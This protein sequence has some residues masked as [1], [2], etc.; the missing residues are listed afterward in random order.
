MRDV[1]LVGGECVADEVGTDIA[2][3]GA[4]SSGDARGFASEC[5]RAPTSAAE[6]MLAEASG[7]DGGEIGRDAL[8]RVP[9]LRWRST[10]LR[11]LLSQY[12]KKLLRK[13]LPGIIHVSCSCKPFAVWSP[14]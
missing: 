5:L 8:A 14:T 1:S 13:D 10:T 11:H 7:E 2:H 9:W 3:G 6:L 4:H 12:Q